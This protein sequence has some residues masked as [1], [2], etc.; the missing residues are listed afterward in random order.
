MSSQPVGIDVS[1][2]GRTLRGLREARGMS[3]SELARRAGSPRTYLIALEQ[4]KH[5]PTLDLLGRIS[6]ALGYPLREV[7]WSL[8]GEPYADPAA[9][10]RGARPAAPGAP[11]AAPGGAGLPRRD[12]PRHHLAD[13]ER[14]QRQPRPGPAGASGRSTTMLSERAGPRAGPG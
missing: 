1:W 12:D 14:D 10:L 4:G 9:P 3:Q 11:R 6:A 7:L 2:V 8:A 5:E 13:R